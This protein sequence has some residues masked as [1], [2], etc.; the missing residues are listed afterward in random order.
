MI[1]DKNFKINALATGVVEVFNAIVQFVFI[2][3]LPFFI[4]KEY[5]GLFFSYKA[6]VASL[7]V[8]FRFAFDIALTRY[9]GFFAG[10]D[11]KQKQVFSSV[12]V[13]FFG[14]T[15]VSFG[16]LF[17]L[18]TILSTKFFDNN[19]VIVF[20]VILTLFLHGIYRL[21]YCFYQGKGS[22]KFANLLRLFIYSGGHFI[23]ILL[24]FFKIISNVETIILCSSLIFVV[25]LIPFVK[26]IAQNFVFDFEFREILEYSIPRIPHMVLSGFLMSANVMLAKY[27][28]SNE[29]AGDLGITTRMFQIIGM[30]AYSFNMVL[31]PKVSELVGKGKTRE[32]Q[33]SLAKYID[34]IVYLGIVGI[35]LF[36]TVTPKVLLFLPKQYWTAEIVLKVFAFAILPYTAYMMLRS[37]IHGIDKKPIQLYIDLTSVSVLFL[38]F[39]IFQNKIDNPLL[40]ISISMTASITVS[41]VVSILYLLKT[42]KII[43]PIQKWFFHFLFVCVLILLSEKSWLVAMAVFLVLEGI[44]GLKYF[45][46]KR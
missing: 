16:F 30:F 19:I 42:L 2:F 25:T 22:I 1:F 38:V 28:F 7:L 35:F 26:I 39:F 20:Y 24:L 27:F 9:L 4:S 45:K 11:Q 6:V 40:L 36:F 44:S 15:I 14:G 8:L 37:V 3:S 21:C 31:L 34:V 5:L 12:L 18:S 43:P 41:G 29:A 33:V 32:L 10:N 13:L 46:V 17:V 23:I